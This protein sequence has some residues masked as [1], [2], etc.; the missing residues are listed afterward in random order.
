MRL[1]P[2]STSA[3]HDEVHGESGDDIVYAGCGNDVVFGDGEDDD[4]IGGWGN[5]WISGGTGQD[6]VL[7]DDGRIFT[8]RNSTPYGEPLYGVAALLA[9]DPD[10]QLS[11]GNVLNE[12]IYTPGNVQTATINVAGELKKTVDLTPFNLTPNALGGDDPLFD[13]DYADD[14][15]FGG[16]GDDFLHGG[17]GDDAISGAEALTE[18]YTPALRRRPA[19]LVGVVRSDFDA[20][21]QPGR[22][23]ALRR[24]RR[25]VAPEAQPSRAGEFAL[26]DEYDPRREILLNADGSTVDRPAP[27][28]R[29]LPQL[30][31]ERGPRS[32]AASTAPN[33]VPTPAATPTATT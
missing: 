15:I 33:G 17:S 13:A 10:T 31:L 20:P 32:P 8:S 27:A 12:F 24:R 7:G 16:L 1:R 28:A 23:A 18:S 11:N 14:I 30:R 2:T 6:G 19:T 5:D 21:V 26:Y 25:R 9:T 3:A 22:P 4:L 29:V